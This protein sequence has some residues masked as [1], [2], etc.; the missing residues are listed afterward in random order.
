M[1]PE[2]YAAAQAA[3]SAETARQVAHLG[4]LFSKPSLAVPDWLVFLKYL[5]SFVSDQRYKSARLGR[6]FYDDQR[7]LTFPELPPFETHLETYDFERFVRDMDPARE[8]MSL[9]DSDSN[10]V[11]Q[12]GLQA[13]R[14]VENGGRHQVIH[15]VEDD[16]ALDPVIE[17]Q[18]YQ[19]PAGSISGGKIVRGWARVAMGHNPCAFCLMLVSR[20]PV[21]YSAEAAGAKTNTD[22][23]GLGSDPSAD[24][25]DLMNQ[26]HPGC[27]CKVVPV[28]KNEGWFGQEQSQRALE[29]WN[30]ATRTA[31]AEQEDDP[32]RTHDFG[33]NNGRQFTR[34]QLA[35]NALRRSLQRGDIAPQEWSALAAA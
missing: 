29:L 7:A 14:T 25:S 21:Y 31:I 23:S 33:K 26:W 15:S 9:A 6:T 16:H 13:V 8:R 32:D 11:G 34:N 2:E 30:Q 18:R 12:L 27:Q 35:L 5:F 3:L 22:L 10:A 28:F 20:G 24:A 19:L 4:G 17:A 1:T